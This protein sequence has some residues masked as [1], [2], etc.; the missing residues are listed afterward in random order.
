MNRPSRL[1]TVAV[2]CIAGASACIDGP[3]ER[4]SPYDPNVVRSVTLLSL[5]DTVRRVGEHAAFQLVS[6]PPVTGLSQPWSTDRPDL[7]SGSVNGRF[8][9][10][11][12]PADT[13]VATMTT[14]IGNRRVSAQVVVAPQ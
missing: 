5:V 1:S 4:S 11:A 14:G 8:E 12:L 10:I 7:F 3:F 13:S 2:L 6:D 9:L